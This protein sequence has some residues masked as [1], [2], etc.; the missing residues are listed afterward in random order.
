MHALDKPKPAET[1]PKKVVSV[2]SVDVE[3]NYVVEKKRVNVTESTTIVKEST[4]NK[5][6]SE[7]S[8]HKEVDKSKDQGSISSARS[9]QGEGKEKKHRKHKHRQQE[10][11]SDSFA[12]QEFSHQQPPPNAQMQQWFAQQG[13]NTSNGGG[14]YQLQQSHQQYQAQ[15]AAYRPPPST[16]SNSSQ[17][18]TSEGEPMNRIFLKPKGD[19]P[20]N[21]N[22]AGFGKQ[23]VPLEAVPEQ[24]PRYQPQPQQQ[25][26]PVQQQQQQPRTHA[27]NSAN[28]F[29][30]AV[31]M[32]NSTNKASNAMM[33]MAANAGKYFHFY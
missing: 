25:Q 30:N 24:M 16:G 33:A 17:S 18:Q 27:M 12:S 22:N 7:D 26:L 4:V 9:D 11:G 29:A 8:T 2:Q 6:T 31:Q 5:S 20:P 10:S 3:E 28:L 21:N 23:S 19:E 14:A 15:N 13:Q 32:Y 1:P